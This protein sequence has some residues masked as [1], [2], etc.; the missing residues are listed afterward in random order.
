M[1]AAIIQENGDSRQLS[2]KRGA[3]SAMVDC[4]R[5]GFS[6]CK[7]L[8]MSIRPANLNTL[9]MVMPRWFSILYWQLA[10]RGKTGKLDS[11]PHANAAKD[12]M[13]LL[14]EQVIRMARASSL[15]NHTLDK[16]LLPFIQKTNSTMT[17]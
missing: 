5:E 9:F 8:G 4:I 7:A 6:V 13:R 3:I 17:D 15:A 16:L 12:E 11:A 1:T 2:K 14:A 10:L